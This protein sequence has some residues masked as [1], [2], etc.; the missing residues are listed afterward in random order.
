[1]QGGPYKPA[2]TRLGSIDAQKVMTVGEQKC[3]MNCIRKY[4]KVYK[5]YNSMESSIFN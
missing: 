1:M 2:D 4:D 5:M 3:G